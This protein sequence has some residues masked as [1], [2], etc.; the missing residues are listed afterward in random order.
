MLFNGTLL[1][2]QLM[3]RQL[4]SE[5]SIF[6]F[7]CERENVIFNFEFLSFSTINSIFL[8]FLIIFGLLFLDSILE[9]KSEVL[10]LALSFFKKISN[11]ERKLKFH[12]IFCK[13]KFLTYGLICLKYVFITVTWVIN[14]DVDMLTLLLM[15]NTLTRLTN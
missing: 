1:K 12:S 3:S 11:F 5:P 8:G 6:P 14:E 2:L 10:N 9:R 7:N 13:H 4:V 15:V